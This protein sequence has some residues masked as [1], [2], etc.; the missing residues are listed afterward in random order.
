MAGMARRAAAKQ[1]RGK[2][3]K[4]KPSRSGDPRRAGEIARGGNQGPG[5]PGGGL[6]EGFTESLAEGLSNLPS[7]LNFPPPG[8]GNIPA[9]FRAN[10]NKRRDDKKK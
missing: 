8:Q 5:G 3:G 9:A 10:P 6:P 4:K 7:G 1:A 2:K